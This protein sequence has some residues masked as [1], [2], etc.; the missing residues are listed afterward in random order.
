MSPLLISMESLPRQVGPRIQSWYLIN[1]SQN[2]TLSDS[3]DKI[4]TLQGISWVT[5]KIINNATITLDIKHYKDDEGAEHIDII[6]TLTGG[7]TSSPEYR[8]LTWTWAKSDHSLFGSV[9]GRSRRIPIADVT[10]EYLK[11]GWLPDVSRDGAIEA[12]VEA[13]KE[14]NPHIWKT[15]MVSKFERHQSCTPRV[16]T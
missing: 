11:S 16:L 14:K 5:R 4:L 2:H 1:P 7:I 3:V 6:Q 10:D 8:T 13:D 15:N 12:Y 9:I